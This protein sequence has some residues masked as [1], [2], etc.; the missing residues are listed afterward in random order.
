MQPP[1][2][3]ALCQDCGEDSLLA[4]IFRLRDRQAPT[5]R[6]PNGLYALPRSTLV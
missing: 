5:K 1:G 3:L 2:E 6:L 4:A